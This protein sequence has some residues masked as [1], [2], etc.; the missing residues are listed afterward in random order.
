[1]MKCT[2]KIICYRT[3]KSERRQYIHF[4]TLEPFEV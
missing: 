1:M 4:Y 2:E 3:S